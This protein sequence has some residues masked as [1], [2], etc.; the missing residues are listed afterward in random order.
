MEDLFAGRGVN[1]PQMLAH[2]KQ[3]ADDLGIPFGHRTMTFNSRHAQEL[4]KWAEAHDRGGAFHNAVFRAYFEHGRNIARMDVLKEVALATGLDSEA[5]E[6][7]L[8]Q[9]QYREP[10]DRDWQYSRQM[11]ITGVP[12]F[13]LQGRVL[14]GA[15]PYATLE[16]WIFQT[17]APPETPQR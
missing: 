2:L 6:N 7:V 3:T 8:G 13:H 14:V 5:I 1:I 11:G 15:Q 10:V 17:D 12:A 4:G 9:G 16:Q